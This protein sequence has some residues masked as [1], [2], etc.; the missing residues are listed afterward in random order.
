MAGAAKP[1]MLVWLA[2]M[3]AAA[4]AETG[5]SLTGVVVDPTRAAVPQA[6]VVLL[7]PGQVRVTDAEGTFRFAGLASGGYEIEVRHE[8]FKPVRM[9]VRVPRRQA[10]PLR[11]ALELAE[12]RQE[13]T[14]ADLRGE[15]GTSPAENP[16]TV[17]LDPELLENLPILGQNILEAASLFLDSSHI[18][19]AGYTLVVDGMESTELGVSASAIREVRINQ[20]PYSAESSSPGKGRI[21]ITT[22]EAA[23]S[24]HGTLNVLFRDHRLDARNAFAASRPPEQRRIY[25]GHLT[26]PISKNRKTSFLVS[27]SREEN[28]L[29]GLVYAE[30]PSGLLRD[31]VP[32]PERQ[33]E[34]SLRIDRRPND[35]R[36]Y[37]WRYEWEA[38][39]ERNGDAGGFTLSEAAAD[40]IERVHRVNFSYQATLSRAVIN[41]LQA[42]I[43]IS[44]DRTRSRQ[45]G[46]PKIVVLD[47]FTGGG[48]Q[49]DRR[50]RDYRAELAEVVSWSR[51][52]HLVKAG[53][54]VRELERHKFYNLS[55]RQ[56]TF[57]FSSLEDYAA[58]TPFSYVAQAGD[59]R[60]LYWTTGTAGFVQ[61]EFRW[62]DNF[63]VGAGVRYEGHTYPADH[64][65]LAPRLSFAFA[66]G[67]Q[68]KTVLRGG[69]GVFY[70]RVGG[71][72]PRDI[73]LLD[74]QRLR[75]IVV[76][77]PGYPDPLSPGASI[78]EQPPSIVRF[79]GDLRSPYL[80]HYSLGASRQV[81]KS[82]LS[83]TYYGV[84]GI[85]MFRSRD[86]NAPVPP[87]CLRPDPAV[88]TLRSIE[89]SARMAGHSLEAGFRGNLSRFFNGAILYT[90]GSTYSDTGG[91]DWLP[92]DSRDL[93]REWARADSDRRHRFQVLGTLKP[94]KLFNL[95]LILRLESGRPY[96]LT[97]G[98]DRNRDGA[99]ND[100]P[101][102]V[103]RNSLQGPGS[104]VLDL[105]W[106]KEFKRR[107][108]PEV[109]LGLDGFNVLN[110][111]NYSG[112]VG[113]TSSPF[114]GL[115]V[116]A[117]PARRLQLSLRLKF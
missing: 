44:D 66:P 83:L 11:V 89:S 34:I 81:E 112:F 43:R 74:G 31:Q 5:G 95:G 67:R 105:R 15:I 14:V 53:L 4:G 30:T 92:A 101:P 77:N 93:S 111:V 82:T 45:P 75:R 59:G 58:G 100:R 10:A 28:D 40:R 8:G 25:E 117:R 90:L 102:G 94:L 84:R 24:F 46:I 110:R 115:P 6:R 104:A 37:S 107:E 91:I 39:S 61:D 7:P 106:S 87:D 20:N 50:S 54:N 71:E 103:R 79:A 86:L 2:A 96:S 3:M 38:D 73:L 70:D 56:G 1:D 99:A 49:A 32:Q 23:S 98:R 51:P 76:T 19:S 55:N 41:Q 52:R 21:E 57:Y 48:A 97:T 63:S 22:A 47:A 27:A 108:G 69:A 26:G 17:R 33:T 42:R 29:Q 9:R 13:L 36:S 35:R 80:V 88:S 65:D 109:T 12:L 116:S 68:R 60:A 113:N 16:D 62:R 18:G 114:F 72:P 78:A 64:N 85:K